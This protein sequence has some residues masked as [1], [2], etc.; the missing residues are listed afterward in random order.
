[1]CHINGIKYFITDMIGCVSVPYKPY[2]RKS[3]NY[4]KLSRNTMCLC[5]NRKI[6]TIC[7]E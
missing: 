5:C 4:I 7:T 2:G 3:L 6:T 1:M